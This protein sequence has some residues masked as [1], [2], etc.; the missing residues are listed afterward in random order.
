MAAVVQQQCTHDKNCH[1]FERQV[2]SKVEEEEL[3]KAAFV[4]GTRRVTKSSFA[5]KKPQILQQCSLLCAA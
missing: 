3:S 4:T 2:F 1:Q 5:T